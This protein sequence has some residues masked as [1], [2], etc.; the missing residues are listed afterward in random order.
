MKKRRS[1]DIS[2]LEF[3]TIYNSCNNA[4]EAADKLTTLAREKGKISS[5]EVIDK[6]V[7]SARA[8]MYR[9]KGLNVKSMSN[10]KPKL[11]VDKLNQELATK[12]AI[13]NVQAEPSVN[14]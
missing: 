5:T 11:D 10:K 9:K 6:S 4:Q 3:S 14:I 7:V 12:E 1:F 8:A 13:E 2:S